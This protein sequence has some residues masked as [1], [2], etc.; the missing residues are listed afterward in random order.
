MKQVLTLGIVLLFFTSFTVKSSPHILFNADKT[1]EVAFELSPEK[2]A[3]Y[4]V[5]YKNK[6]GDQ[7]LATRHYP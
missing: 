2:T 5:F 3:V 7:Y 4:R 6:F 1:I